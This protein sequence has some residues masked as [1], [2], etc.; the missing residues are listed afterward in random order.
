MPPARL[1]AGP[2]AWPASARLQAVQI[3]PPL[4]FY[5]LGARVEHVLAPREGR[6]SVL[7]A[8]ALQLPVPFVEALLEFGAI[9]TCPVPPTPPSGALAAGQAEEIAQVRQA[10]AAAA[11][12][13][14]ND[15]SR[16]RPVGAPCACPGRASFGPPS[17]A[18]PGIA[19]GGTLGWESAAGVLPGPT[20]PACSC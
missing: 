10:A 14:Q 5:G 16:A 8:E 7:V 13:R 17:P 6:L 2:P 3:P 1:P 20:C 18:L 15:V 12:G 11:G 19:G 4:G 9:Y